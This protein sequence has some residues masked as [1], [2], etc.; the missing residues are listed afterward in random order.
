VRGLFFEVDEI[1][2]VVLV[3]NDCHPERGR[4][5]R[6]ASESRDLL[7]TAEDAEDE[8]WMPLASS[9]GGR[10][11]RPGRFRSVLV[12][13]LQLI[14]VLGRHGAMILQMSTAPISPR[15]KQP[16]FDWEAVRALFG[17][18]ATER[19]EDVECE[20]VEIKGFWRTPE[21]KGRAQIAG[22]QQV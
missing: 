20:T 17:R 10:Q 7:F 9:K 3:L 15:E 1:Q 6:L 11:S 21:H 16:P 2:H 18:L 5:D 12:V 4:D 14:Q 22:G 8:R 13:G 19:A